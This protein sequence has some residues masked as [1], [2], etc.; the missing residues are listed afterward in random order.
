[1]KDLLDVLG[2]ILLFAVLITIVVVITLSLFSPTTLT[3]I[4]ESIFGS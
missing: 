4:V 1:M 3:S 2:I